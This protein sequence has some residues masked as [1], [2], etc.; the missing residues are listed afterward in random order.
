[1][2]YM[3]HGHPNTHYVAIEMGIAGRKQE[4]SW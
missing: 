4:K 1:M 3:E 2:Y